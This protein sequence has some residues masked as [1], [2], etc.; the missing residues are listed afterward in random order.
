L[1]SNFLQGNQ[2]CDINTYRGEIEQLTPVYDWLERETFNRISPLIET[3]I[4]NLKKINYLMSVSPRTNELDDFAKADV[5]TNLLRYLQNTTNFEEKKNTLIA[6]NEL[7]GSAFWLSWWD[8]DAGEEYARVKNVTVDENGEEKFT[9]KSINTGDIN[10]GL[11]TPFEVYPESIFKQTV[12]NNRSI[13]IEQVKTVEEIYDLYDLKI[14]GTTIDTFALNHIVGGGGFGHESSVTALTTRTVDNSQKVVTYFEKPTRHKP[15]GRLIIIVGETEIVYCGKLPY[16]KI[17]L[18]QV[19]CKEVAGQFFGKSVIEDLIPLQRSYNGCINR[20]HEFIKNIAIDSYTAE[21]GSIDIEEYEE[22]GKAPGAILTYKKGHA[23]PQPIRNGT[24]PSEVMIERRELKTDMEYVAGVSQLMVTG[25][26]P[27]GVT[28]GTA[29]QNLREIDNTRLSLTGDHIRN[30]VRKL[31]EI[32]LYIYKEFATTRRVLQ[33]VGSN[34]IGNILTW[35]NED[36]NSFDIKFDTVNELLLSEDM[37]KQ[38]FFEAYNLGLFTGPDG[39]IPQRVKQRALEYMKIGNYSEVMNINQLQIQ[40][41]QRENSFFENGVLPEITQID[42]HDIHIDEHTR[43]VL[44]MKYR[45]M[46]KK[47]PDYAAK[48]MEHLMQHKQIIAQEI[49]T[50][51][52]AQM[53]QQIEKG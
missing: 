28:S 37:Q 31:A 9:E 38:R 46:Q 11:L 35:S 43:Y 49:L 12:E 51:M 19:S 32:W 10:Y 16:R 39:T 29:I 47:K 17:P 34:D 4:A 3:R 33:F 36:I 27:T 42:D 13:I 22:N 18:V 14:D 15:D 50:Q 40:A 41:A 52:Q 7:C 48:M 45:I 20:I 5:S 1:N 6:W 23:P 8:T 26:A 53:Q 30:S 2:F 24:L 21:E 44:Q 25:Q